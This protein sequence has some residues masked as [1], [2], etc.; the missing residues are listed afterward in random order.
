MASGGGEILLQNGWKE[1]ADHYSVTYGHLLLFQY[2]NRNHDFHVIIFDSSATEIEYPSSAHGTG[3]RE[4]RQVEEPEADT[5]SV[6]I[7]E[8]SSNVGNKTQKPWKT[9]SSARRMQPILGFE[10][11]KTLCRASA[12]RSTNP[13]FKIMMQPSFVHDGCKLGVPS[14]FAKQHFPQKS[15]DNDIF[16]SLSDSGRSW[17]VNYLLEI[18]REGRTRVKFLG[19]WR[20]FAVDNNLVVGD[21]CVFELRNI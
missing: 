9:E 2:K 17:R 10:K 12:F 4:Y 16:L 1:F 21:V 20:E 19:G 8:E 3:F 13:F 18:E 5:S 14:G 7:K 15:G 11:T 6:E